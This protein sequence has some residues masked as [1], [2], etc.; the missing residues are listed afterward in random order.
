VYAGADIIH[1]VDA[2]LVPKVSA[3][4]GGPAPSVADKVAA[5]PA[6][7][8]ANMKTAAAAAA[9]KADSAGRRKLLRTTNRNNIAS[10]TQRAN[11]RRAMSGTLAVDQATALNGR[12]AALAPVGRVPTYFLTSGGSTPRGGFLVGGPM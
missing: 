3:D 11:I 5:M 12:V 10:N 6:A 1:K 8:A 9:P 7:A 4:A 2:V